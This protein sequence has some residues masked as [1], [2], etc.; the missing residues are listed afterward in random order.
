MPY[1]NLDTNGSPVKSDVLAFTPKEVTAGA[2]G[3][4]TVKAGPGVVVFVHVATPGLGVSLKDGGKRVW[5]A[6]V[7]VDEDDFSLFPLQF[8]DSI[9]LSFDGAG[10]AYIACR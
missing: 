4:I 2:A 1:V 8:G 7:G 3:D 6:L 10:T 5:P 9:V